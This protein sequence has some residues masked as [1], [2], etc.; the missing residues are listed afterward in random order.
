ML[1]QAGLKAGDRRGLDTETESEI[2]IWNIKRKIKS[3]IDYRKGRL[4]LAIAEKLIGREYDRLRNAIGGTAH[5]LAP[6]HELT[7]VGH[8]YYNSR[9]GGGEGHLEVAKNIYYC[10]KDYSHMV[11]SL[12]PF[13][14]MPST[15]SDGAQAAVVSH[16]KDM[17]Y[18]PIE[19]SG[20]GDINAHSRVQMALGEAKLKCKEEFKAV[21]ERTGYS[22]EQ[23]RDFVSEHR[24]LRRPLQH[25]P[26]HKG[27]ISR[28][29]N[30]VLYVA[31]KMR[32]AGVQPVDLNELE[33]AST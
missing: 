25:V 22:I 16:F 21:V 26:H 10:N 28:A 17:I 11:L 1:H 5:G 33:L 8:P 30:F 2:P 23:I 27:V 12:K 13:G 3:E 15:Q 32:A 24:D 31:E 20:E 19:T 7:R 6:Q 4:N 9:S 14:C 29:G 18:I